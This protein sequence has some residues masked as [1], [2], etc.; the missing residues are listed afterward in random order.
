MSL[1]RCLGDEEV[2]SGQGEVEVRV[3]D[4]GE[5]EKEDEEEKRDIR[6]SR[7]RGETR[8]ATSS[9]RCGQRR[10]TRSASTLS[11]PL[12]SHHLALI[13]AHTCY[14]SPNFVV[15]PSGFG[16]YDPDPTIT[17]RH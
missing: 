8:T 15:S 9:G 11:G 12:H 7:A 14:R 17:V 1:V 5:D 10:V 13:D 4:E 3:K 6:L 16:P 2:G